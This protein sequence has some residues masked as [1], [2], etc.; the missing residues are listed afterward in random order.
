M[1]TKTVH[2]VKECTQC[3]RSWAVLVDASV[4]DVQP[5]EREPVICKACQ[6]ECA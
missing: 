1:D 5:E 2:H 6:K 3:H 4:A